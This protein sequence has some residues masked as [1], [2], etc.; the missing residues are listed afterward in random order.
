[1]HIQV[2]K[3]RPKLNGDPTSELGEMTDAI[4]KERK[5]CRNSGKCCGLTLDAFF[6]FQAC[7]EMFVSETESPKFSH[8]ELLNL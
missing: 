1:M 3:P 6:N 4:S 5:F 7:F 8:D 2:L